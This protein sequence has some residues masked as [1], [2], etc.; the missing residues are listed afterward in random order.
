MICPVQILF[1]FLELLWFLGVVATKVTN[2]LLYFK[3]WA[4]CQWD[5]Q[6]FLVELLHLL[7][8][9][10]FLFFVTIYVLVA[11]L[12]ICKLLWNGSWIIRQD[13]NCWFC[14]QLGG[15]SQH[16]ITKKPSAFCSHSFPLFSSSFSTAWLGSNDKY[17][18]NFWGQYFHCKV[19]RRYSIQFV[20]SILNFQNNSPSQKF[21]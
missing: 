3:G 1:H 17:V 4:V 9:L 14:W 5:A 18:I 6:C 12:L 19:C 15:K 20:I 16:C 13:S 2:R 7:L 8:L 11:L 10:F 21:L